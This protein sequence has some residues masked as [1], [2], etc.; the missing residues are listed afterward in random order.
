MGKTRILLCGPPVTALGGGPTHIRNLLASPLG[1]RFEI[2]HF[3]SGSRGTESPA[4]DEGWPRMILR[5]ATSPFTLAGRILRGRPAVIHLNSAMDPKAFWRDA[6]YVL[7]A[8]LLG[9]S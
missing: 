3:E 2:E 9:R 1:D 4:K 5:I 8:R 6:A 7:V